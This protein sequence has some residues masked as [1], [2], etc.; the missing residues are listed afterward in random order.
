MVQSC[1][2]PSPRREVPMDFR[3]GTASCLRPRHGRYWVSAAGTA[4][5]HIAEDDLELYMLDRLA[6]PSAAPVEEHQLVSEEW[7]AR[8]AE[9]SSCSHCCALFAAGNAAR[10]KQG[11]RFGLD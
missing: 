1:N 7:R 2:V 9:V 4:T 10:R 11:W 8:L 5:H 3:R 6:E